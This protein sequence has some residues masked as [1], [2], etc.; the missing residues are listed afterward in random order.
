ML[1]QETNELLCRV[2]LGTP[3]GELLRRYWQPV[4]LNDF[5][6][7][8]KRRNAKRINPISRA[9]ARVFGA[10]A[11]LRDRNIYPMK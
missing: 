2:G 3:M 5:S 6:D 1:E 11:L 4:A 10:Q 8:P 7:G 9:Y